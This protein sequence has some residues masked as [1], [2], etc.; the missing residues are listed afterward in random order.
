VNKKNKTDIWAVGI[1][2][3][4]ISK[5]IK[6]KYKSKKDVIW[7]YPKKPYQFYADPFGIWKDEKLY[8]FVEALDY[9]IKKGEID[10]FVFDK[11]LKRIDFHHVL[12]NKYHLSYPFIVQHKNKI[13]MIP[14]SSQSGKTFIYEAKNFP[15]KWEK[16][17][18]IMKNVPMIDPSIIKYQKKWWIF[19]SLPGPNGRAMKELN[20]AFSENLLSCWKE[21]PNNP[22][23][24]DIENSRPGG[25]PFII[26]NL[27][28]LPVQNCKKTYGGEIN[29]LKIEK[30]TE[31]DFKATSVRSIKPNLNKKYSDGLHTL[32][33]CKSVTLIDCKNHNYSS[34]RKWIDWQRRLGRFI[35]FILKF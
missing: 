4:K 32:S 31:N 2:N 30:L 29:I 11:N 1:I 35:P 7:I 5:F 17:K 26:D 18:E 27:I 33:K 9:R 20:V 19:Y 23:K 3:N 15:K 16:I 22:V 34:K 25:T 12:S 8:I 6:N 10:C 28:H 21:H 24:V 13:Y 14:E